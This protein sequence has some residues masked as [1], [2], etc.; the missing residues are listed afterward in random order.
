MDTNSPQY[1][2]VNGQMRAHFGALFAVL[3]EQ[4]AQALNQAG[5]QLDVPYGAHPREVMDLL[6][7]ST[8]ARG[9]VVYF[10]AGYWQSR[11]K[12]QFRFLAPGFQT[13]GWHTA[14]VNYPLCPE[15][16]VAQIVDSA[17]RALSHV[18]QRQQDSGRAGPLVL[19]G[20]SA[21]AHL[22]IELALQ[23]AAGQ[24]DAP[25]AGVVAISGVY[26]LQPLIG[27]TLNERLR[28]DA[29][30]ALA[31]SPTTRVPAGAAP[32]LFVWGAAETPAFHE[33]S[34]HMARLWQQQ[35]NRAEC[36]AVEA[37]DHFS[38]L[39]HVM[40]PDGPLARA[41]QSWSGSSASH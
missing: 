11:D 37:A 40:R 14:L 6:P 29:A 2:Y 4:N 31:S 16:T 28:L 3:E 34:Q 26:D 9:T 23:L 18:C 19:C 24:I 39:E 33:Q 13:M 41:L 22:A 7:A 32:A 27:T 15:V 10:H 17:R 20:H 5:W 35:G 36:L 12:S 1:Q 8:N 25:V 30:S 38:V 21:G